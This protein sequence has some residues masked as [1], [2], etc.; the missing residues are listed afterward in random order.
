[1]ANG[2]ILGQT[3]DSFTKTQTLSET[4]AAL[5]GL[6]NTAVPNDVLNI[7][8][9]AALFRAAYSDPGLNSWTVASDPRSSP[10]TINQFAYN[11]TVLVISSTGGGNPMVSYDRGKTW[12]T[13]VGDLPTN[14]LYS[15]S[16]YNGIIYAWQTDTSGTYYTSTDGQNWSKHTLSNASGFK[17]FWSFFYNGVLC[18]VGNSGADFF[19]QTNGVVSLPITAETLCPGYV[20]AEGTI[21]L[22]EQAGGTI[23]KSTDGGQT[24]STASTLP[25]GVLARALGYKDGVFVVANGG[26]GTTSYTSADLVTWT[27]GANS[28]IAAQPVL[29]GN[30]Y[31]ILPYRRLYSEDGLTWHQYTPNNYPTGQEFGAFFD[32]TFILSPRE[33]PYAIYTADEEIF[34]P[35]TLTDVQ[36][37]PLVLSNAK[38][39]YGSYIGSGT[40]GSS[41]PTQ[42]PLDDDPYFVIVVRSSGY[43]YGLHGSEDILIWVKGMEGTSVQEDGSGGIYL[44]TS[45]ADGVF[46]FY[47]MG[48]NNAHPQLNIAGET[49]FYLS[50]SIG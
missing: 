22:S 21:Y 6:Q 44:N 14:L 8:A 25:S 12:S 23:I 2:A 13:D 37:N 20:V 50:I 1:M 34:S 27:P 43:D 40:S 47:C 9:K 31:F 18:S 42:I 38:L 24:W 35:P 7:L 19:S 45:Y 17:P 30:K 41:N 3:T 5:Y 46:R 49:Y 4:V 11:G 33:A 16:E 26:S 36:G 48:N 15:L 10:Y 28:G 29:V 39:T 32:G